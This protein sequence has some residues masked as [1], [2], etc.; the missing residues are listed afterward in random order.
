MIDNPIILTVCFSLAGYLVGS[1]PF[2]VIIARLHGAD[3]RK[4]GSGNVGATN[5]GRV[6][7]KPWGI[8]CFLLD[9]AKGLAPTLTVMFV[10]KALPGFPSPLHQLAWLGAGAGCI[11]GHVFPFWLGFR[12][13]RGV[14]T[15][16]GVVLGVFPFF[17]WAG[18]AALGVW[19]LVTLVT[20]YVS[21]GSIAAACAFLPLF[22][23]FNATRWRG[24]WPLL[25]FA[26]A[27][28]VLIVLRHRAN[29]RRL[30]SGTENRIGRPKAE[31]A[32]G[33]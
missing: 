20:R 14:A 32:G 16:L 17:T 28:V 27:M 7:G 19:I 8:F 26:G 15:A 29:I 1:T 9:A 25:A 5:V 21:L 6:V 31:S 30:L 4:S 3:L 33:E 12:G 24:L 13:G 10:L 18:L 2:G 23:A 11:L 22:V